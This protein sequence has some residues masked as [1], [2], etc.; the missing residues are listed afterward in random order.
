MNTYKVRTIVPSLNSRQY[1]S[2]RSRCGSKVVA[3]TVLLHMEAATGQSAL[4]TPP[5]PTQMTTIPATPNLCV[6]ADVTFHTSG[7]SARRVCAAGD[8]RIRTLALAESELNKRRDERAQP[9]NFARAWRVGRSASIA[10]LSSPLKV[11]SDPVQHI[12]TK[13]QPSWLPGLLPLP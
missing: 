13:R 1:E 2:Q 7:S 10:S 11:I 6:R 9:W 12:Q 8:D 5:S 4:T 3:R